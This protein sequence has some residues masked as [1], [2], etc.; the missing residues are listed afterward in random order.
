MTG[1]KGDIP[2]STEVLD[3]AESKRRFLECLHPDTCHIDRRHPHHAQLSEIFDLMYRKGLK[4]SVV[5]EIINGVMRECKDDIEKGCAIVMI[6][7]TKLPDR[8][9]WQDV[10]RKALPHGQ[11]IDLKRESFANPILEE[12]VRN[13]D[14]RNTCSAMRTDLSMA[15]AI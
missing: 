1:T 4:P 9:H 2:P 13:A 12:A 5:R 8:D 10:A 3:Y 7:V 6:I 11:V 15:F 14:S